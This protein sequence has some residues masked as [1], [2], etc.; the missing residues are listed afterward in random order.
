MF[1]VKWPLYSWLLL[2]FLPVSLIGWGQI[3]RGVTITPTVD[4]DWGGNK[5]DVTIATLLSAGH[6]NHHILLGFFLFYFLFLFLFSHKEE[7]SKEDIGFKDASSLL[8]SPVFTTGGGEQREER[9]R[10]YHN[11]PPENGGSF[12]TEVILYWPQVSVRSN[13]I[14]LEEMCSSGFIYVATCCCCWRCR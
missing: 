5:R 7:G 3:R 4:D 9:R 14:H 10:L 6:H 1:G 12:S 8:S 13:K 11:N 2:L